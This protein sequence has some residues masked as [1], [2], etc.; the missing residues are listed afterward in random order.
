MTFSIY[1]TWILIWLVL[2]LSACSLPA[3][4]NGDDLTPTTPQEELA[5][6]TAQVEDTARPAMAVVGP[7]EV[8]F[9]WSTDACDP[10]DIPD[11]PARAFQDSEGQVHLVSSHLISRASVGPNLDDLTHQCAPIMIS[12]HN[13][14]PAMFNDNEWIAG[15]Y[16]EDGQ[17]VFASIHNEYHGWEHGDCAGFPSGSFAC[18]YNTLTWAISTDG[19]NSFIDAF[20]P[21]AHF[22]AGLPHPYEAGAGPYGV[23]E[24][25]NI[26]KAKDGYYYQFAKVDD[27]RS[28]DQWACLM[29]TDNLADPASWRAWGGE[30]FDVAFLDIYAHPEANRENNLC[31]PIAQD[32]IGNMTQSVTYNTFL[33][34][35]VLVGLSADHLDG[36]EVWGIYYAFSDDMVHWTHRKLLWERELPWTWQPGDDQTLL[37]PALLDPDSP[38]LSFETTGQQVYL[39]YTT[40]NG[41]NSLDR[42]LI[43]VPVAFFQSEAE[44]LAAD[45]RTQLT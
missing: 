16:T 20:S 10:E 12:D 21:P 3:E 39:Y 33:D 9:D 24:P 43:R 2:L 36:R 25:S 14:D 26:L 38:S 1:R 34:R 23:M 42:D 7:E 4:S 32:E 44:A 6:T 45:T 31:V 18:W 29:R 27:Y 5:P 35:Y 28:D 15:L 19:G 17:T 8:V 22:V 30:V 37:Y 40:F 13:A 11:L 41:G